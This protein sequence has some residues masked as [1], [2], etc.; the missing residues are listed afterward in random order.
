MEE[1]QVKEEF[2]Q[3]KVQTNETPEVGFPV[4]QPKRQ[5]K[6][7][8]VVFVI[9]GLLIIIGTVAFFISRRSANETQ[10]VTP[11][12]IVEGVSEF[13]TDTPIPVSTPKAKNK[14]VIKIEIQNG[15]GISREAAYLQTLLKGIGY[16]NLKV[17]NSD[18]DNYETTVVTFNKTLDSDIVSEITTKLE[19]VY[20]NVDTKTSESTTTDVLVITG[21]RKGVTPK[22]S[23]TPKSQASVSPSPSSL[24]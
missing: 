16:S 3:E 12:P 13:S 7:N 19:E 10:E 15:T 8:I 20:K 5:S 23:A 9:L 2:G 24:P 6:T 17:G 21:L 18:K 14:G 4:S 11:S 22:P 1:G